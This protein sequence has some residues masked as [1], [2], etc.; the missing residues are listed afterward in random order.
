MK[1]MLNLMESMI[2]DNNKETGKFLPSFQRSKEKLLRREV[3][4]MNY[5]SLS[6]V[7]GFGKMSGILLISIYL[8]YGG[9]ICR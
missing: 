9:R 6:E 1:R 3:S 2:K 8:G 7:S 5:L 4:S